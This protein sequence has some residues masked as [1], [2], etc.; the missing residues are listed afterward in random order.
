MILSVPVF[1]IIYEYNDPEGN[2]EQNIYR[3]TFHAVVR[4]IRQI[5][6]NK[7]RFQ[8]GVYAG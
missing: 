3:P 6:K 1:L 2:A 4:K 8:G 5:I 7:P